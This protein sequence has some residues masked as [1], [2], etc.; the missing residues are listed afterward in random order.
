VIPIYVGEAHAGGLGWE[1]LAQ[2]CGLATWEQDERFEDY[3]MFGILPAVGAQLS[4][5]RCTGGRVVRARGIE[6]GWRAAQSAEDSGFEIK[7]ELRRKPQEAPDGTPRS[8]DGNYAA[9]ETTGRTKSMRSMAT[10][11]P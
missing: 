6:C 5:D 11:I 1:L 10:A 7:H 4:K 3:A 2:V 9:L 8:C